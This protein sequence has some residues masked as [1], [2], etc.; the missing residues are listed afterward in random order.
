[1]SQS[2]RR[3]GVPWVERVKDAVERRG[4]GEEVGS[5]EVRRTGCEAWMFG[6]MEASSGGRETEWEVD[7]VGAKREEGGFPIS[8]DSANPVQDVI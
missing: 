8:S 1:M 7:V 5:L 6:E 2:W 4:T 3:T